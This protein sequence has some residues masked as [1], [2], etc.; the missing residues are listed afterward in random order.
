MA[1]PWVKRVNP[2]AMPSEWLA[3]DV[4]LGELAVMA[5]ALEHPEH[6]FL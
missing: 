4:G 1:Y 3:L 5:L 2:R 6:V